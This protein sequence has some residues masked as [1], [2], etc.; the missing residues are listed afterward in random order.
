CSSMPTMWLLLLIC[1]R[2]AVTQYVWQTV[3]HKLPPGFLPNFGEE[4]SMDCADKRWWIYPEFAPNEVTC[5]EYSKCFLVLVWMQIGD[6]LPTNLIRSFFYQG[7][8]SDAICALQSVELY[9]EVKDDANMLKWHLECSDSPS[10]R[11]R[12]HISSRICELELH[13]RKRGA[14]NL[15]DIAKLDFQHHHNSRIKNEK[16]GSEN[17]EDNT[18]MIPPYQYNRLL[19]KAN[20]T[21]YLV[22]GTTL[23]VAMCFAFIV[24]LQFCCSRNKIT[25]DTKHNSC[26]PPPISRHIFK[27][28]LERSGH[29][30]D[31]EKAGELDRGNDKE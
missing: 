20:A 6:I 10:M 30:R 12:H 18:A 2:F 25:K 29:Q 27:I 14:I 22:A 19:P 15:D 24:T 31:R 3:E 26:L 28:E 21:G 7:N 11:R 9:N 17:G 1:T 23:I 13:R 16:R 5:L 8:S 4:N